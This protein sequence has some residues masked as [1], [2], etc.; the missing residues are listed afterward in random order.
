MKKE[1][2]DILCC[3]NCKSTLKLQIEKEVNNEIISGFL[4]CSQC[5]KRYPITEGIPDFIDENE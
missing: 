3:P 2:I 5:D 4:I 1:M